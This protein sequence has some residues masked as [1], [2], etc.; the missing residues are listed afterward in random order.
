MVDRQPPDR[1]FHKGLPLHN[2]GLAKW[3]A[4]DQQAAFQYT[5]EAFVE[6]ALSRG[7]ESPDVP[8]ELERPAANNLLWLF[9]VPLP[10]VARL[11]AQIRLAQAGGRL[12]RTAR[13]ALDAI[14]AGIRPRPP[15]AAGPPPIRIPGQFTSRWRDRVFVGGAYEVIAALRDIGGVVRSKG[16]DAVMAFEFEIA[17]EDAHHH[18]LMLLHECRAAIFEVSVEAGQLIELERTRD[19]M[20]TDVLVLYQGTA[21]HTK[22][23]SGMVSALLGRL[24]IEPVLYADNSELAGIIG[25]WVD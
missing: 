9:E 1:R 6:D 18:A 4:R 22:H 15:V 19:Y 23:L 7:E 13:D 11:S 20:I 25:P 5:L 10:H 12:Y 2:M 24:R 21:G 16:R 14:G 3:L 17:P 8:D